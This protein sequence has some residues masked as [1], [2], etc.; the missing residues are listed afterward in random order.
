[1]TSL[2]RVLEQLHTAADLS[3]I[4]DAAYACFTAMLPVIEQ[5]Q[6]PSNPLFAPFVLA[7]TSAANGRLALAA[8]PSLS[9]SARA[10]MLAPPPEADV[11]ARD[12]V[13][14]IGHVAEVLYRRLRDAAL[15][16]AD[17]AD[18]QACTTAARHAADVGARC[19]RT[20]L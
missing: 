5:Q 1:M 19:G 13:L 15:T 4:L 3:A 10:L 9:S 11:P 2:S 8:A 17:A 18:R 12:A 16:A 7:G 6:D 14:T 20:P